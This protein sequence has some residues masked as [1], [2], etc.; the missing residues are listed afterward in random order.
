M[1]QSEYAMLVMFRFCVITI[2][3]RK[4]GPNGYKN[5]T[6]TILETQLSDYLPGKMADTPGPASAQGQT[7]HPIF[8]KFHDMENDGWTRVMLRIE[9]IAY[10]FLLIPKAG[11][12]GRDEACKA[13]CEEMIVK[14]YKCIDMYPTGNETTFVIEMGKYRIDGLFMS[15]AVEVSCIFGMPESKIAQAVLRSGVYNKQGD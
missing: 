8:N 9:A 14:L 13:M 15:H 4:H 7:T 10:S 12:R 6:S 3:T 1:C 5:R 2:S 11:V